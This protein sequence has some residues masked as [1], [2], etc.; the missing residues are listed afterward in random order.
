LQSPHTQLNLLFEG[1]EKSTN[2]T[3]IALQQDYRNQTL[4]VC[5]ADD[6]GLTLAGKKIIAVKNCTIEN[7]EQNK[8]QEIL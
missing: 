7:K 1:A 6:I 5:P 4:T 2:R 8:T 3:N